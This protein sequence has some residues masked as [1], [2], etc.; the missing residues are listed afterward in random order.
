MNKTEHPTQADVD[1]ARAALEE[2]RAELGRRHQRYLDSE[3]GATWDD[4]LDQRAALEHAEAEM[5]RATRAAEKDEDSHR[6]GILAAI[7]LEV[8]QYAPDL[9]ER[10]AALLGDV[11]HA[12]IELA[13][14]CATHNAQLADW[15]NRAVAAGGS[16][17]TSDSQWLSVTPSGAIKAGRRELSAVYS[18]L[19]IQELIDSMPSFTGMPEGHFRPRQISHIGRASAYTLLQRATTENP[20]D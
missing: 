17:D 12:V 3:P 1:A 18:G 15:R 2:H 11:E 8:D 6:Q 9:T 13:Q 14:T 19:A 7:R 10:L 20:E 4:V 5:Q 16:D